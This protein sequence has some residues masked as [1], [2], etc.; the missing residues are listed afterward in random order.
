MALNPGPGLKDQ[1]IDLPIAGGLNDANDVINDETN[2]LQDAVD[3]IIMKDHGITR[4]AG[5]NDSVGFTSAYPNS[6]FERDG[7]VYTYAEGGFQARPDEKALIVKSLNATSPRPCEVKVDSLIRKPVD[8]FNPESTSLNGY[9]C[10]VYNHIAQYGSEFFPYITSNSSTGV[11][12]KITDEVTGAILLETKLSDYAFSPRCVKLGKYFLVTAIT[13]QSPGVGE[14][15]G[16]V[17][18]LSY[19]NGTWSAGFLVGGGFSEVSGYD[20]CVS[21]NTGAKAAAFLAA[22]NAFGVRLSKV[23]SNLVVSHNGQHAHTDIKCISVCHCPMTD[24]VWTAT[25]EN[26]GT[27]SEIKLYSTAATSFAFGFAFTSSCTVNDYSTSYAVSATAP[28]YQRVVI[29]Q[30]DYVTGALVLAWSWGCPRGLVDAPSAWTDPTTRHIAYATESVSISPVGAVVAD[31]YAL[32]QGY[33]IASKP[34]LQAPEAEL[35]GQTVMLLAHSDPPSINLAAWS[36]VTTWTN[37]SLQTTGLLVTRALHTTGKYSYCHVPVARLFTDGLYST[38]LNSPQAPNLCSSSI[39]G[40]TLL[41]PGNV[42]T[43]API[44]IS[45]TPTTAGINLARVSRRTDC[46]P[47]RWLNVASST[48]SHGGMHVITDGAQGYENSF[49]HYPETPF[50]EVVLP[51]GGGPHPDRAW[52]V[53]ATANYN[54]VVAWVYWDNDGLEHRSGVSLPCNSGISGGIVNYPRLYVPTPPLGAVTNPTLR[55]FS[56]GD[57]SDTAVPANTYYLVAEVEYDPANPTPGW[58]GITLATYAPISENTELLYTSGGV[59]ESLAPPALRD[60]CSWKDVLVGIDAEDR[61][62]LWYTK[63]FEPGIAPEWN[64]ALTIRIPSEGGDVVSISALDEKLVVLK[65]NSIY[66]CVGSTRD[67]LGEGSDPTVN[68]VASDVGCLGRHTTAIV[69]DGLLFLANHGRGLVMLDRG[70]T[71]HRL[72]A[73]EDRFVNLDLL[74]ST[75]VVPYESAVRWGFTDGRAVYLNYDQGSFTRFTNYFGTVHHTVIN[76]RVWLLN[77]TQGDYS[78]YEESGEGESPAFAAPYWQVNTAWVKLGGINGYQRLRRV[79]LAATPPSYG[80]SLG[81]TLKLSAWVNYQDS[82][83]AAYEATWPNTAFGVDGHQLGLHVPVQKCSSVKFQINEVAVSPPPVEAYMGPISLTQL[84]LRIGVKFTHAKIAT[85]SR[86]P[87]G[88]AGTSSA[89]GDV[90]PGGGGNPPPPID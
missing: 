2:L 18:N 75:V 64:P 17:F 7:R 86:T 8:V 77:L 3:C 44:A 79:L 39:N 85:G 24:K 80:T 30:D 51:G 89:N 13:E 14:I 33:S 23:T 22:Y 15:T 9:V 66:Y 5:V 6:V 65:E 38:P 76:G 47:L 1:V 36:G 57:L 35:G 62:L 10:T 78:I 16:W 81:V 58:T 73:P 55:V 37:L 19:P 72:R 68:R 12:A 83:A 61:N 70:M 56:T 25:F 32:A 34:F 50:C 11:Y 52:Y 28:S 49:H 87:V 26:I 31:T 69:P 54:F 29:E 4:R 27:G 46:K 84:S 90:I 40:N 45:I 74:H 42:Y 21:T 63:P 59:L 41:V 43:R 71:T 82:G 67:S 60:I 88:A 20:I 48:H 53:T